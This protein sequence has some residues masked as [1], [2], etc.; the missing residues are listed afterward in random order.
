MFCNLFRHNFRLWAALTIPFLFALG[1]CASVSA[2]EEK[3][4]EL[5]ISSTGRPS[6]SAVMRFDARTGA[7]RGQLDD[8][9]AD[10]ERN[11]YVL[12]KGLA[13]DPEN[14]VYVAYRCSTCDN[15]QMAAILKFALYTGGRFLT[16][17]AFG[18][19]NKMEGFEG[20]AISPDAL[21]LYADQREFGEIYHYE[22]KSK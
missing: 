16:P 6:E 21:D 2:A 17:F 10:P 8:P 4:V 12:P 20:V 13:V 1:L 7:Y 3:M 15:P 9:D 22:F 18:R 11:Q 5:L 19:G 14:Q